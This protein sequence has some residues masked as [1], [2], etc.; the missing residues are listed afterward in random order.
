MYFDPSIFEQKTKIDYY[1]IDQRKCHQ[2]DFWSKVLETSTFW[3]YIMLYRLYK[4]Y[5][6]IWGYVYLF[7]VTLI[8]SL[9]VFSSIISFLVLIYIKDKLLDTLSINSF[10]INHI[11]MKIFITSMIEVR[12]FKSDLLR[13]ILVP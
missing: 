7:T 3:E 8:K 13:K 6:A 11:I 2:T 12:S 1:N 10:S 4:L 5:H 9:R